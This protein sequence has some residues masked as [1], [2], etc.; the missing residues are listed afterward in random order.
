MR[1]TLV[2]FTVLAL[3]GVSVWWLQHPPRT[4]DDYRTRSADTVESL[5][6]Y[7][8]TA[9]LWS[10]EVTDGNVTRAAASVAFEESS[11][12]AEST[13]ASFEAWVPPQQL[14]RVRTRVSDAAAD[15]TNA[16]GEVHVAAEQDDWRLVAR[17]EQPLRELESR[18]TRI[19]SEVRR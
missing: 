15:T 18:L 19:A 17:A 13:A 1:A 3:A 11:T 5:R 14:N 6:S 7:V 2:A 10:G 8:A 9:R 16:L 4:A 12:G